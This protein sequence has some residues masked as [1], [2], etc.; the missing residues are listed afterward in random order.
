[1][2]I[3]TTSFAAAAVLERRFGFGRNIWTVPPDDIDLFLK[4]FFSYE[5]IY[6]LALAIIKIS[7]CFLYLRIFPSHRFRITVW[8][9]QVF[10]VLLVVSFVIADGLQC[11][12][13]SYFWQGW[14]GEHVGYCVN[15]EA[16]VYSHAGINIALDVWML[17]LPASQIWHLNLSWKKKAGVTSMFGFG[18]LCVPMAHSHTPLHLEIY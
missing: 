2:Q 18:I 9:T 3:L 7:I 8:A 11:R 6:V 13:I 14:D 15:L 12:P 16:F 1:M 17:A 4:V 5:A 10:N